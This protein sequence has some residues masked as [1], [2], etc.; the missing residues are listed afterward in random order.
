MTAV[1]GGSSLGPNTVGATIGGGG[2][3]SS[4]IP[5]IVTTLK[6]GSAS[7]TANTAL[8]SIG[9]LSS[10]QV[11]L[12]GG[13][14]T[15][16]HGSSPVT[17]AS[18]TLGVIVNNTDPQTI[19]LSG[20]NQTL[21]AG[22]GT[23]TINAT[24][25][26]DSIVSGG[27]NNVIDFTSTSTNGQ[28]LGDGSNWVS[29]NSASGTTTV[30]ATPS[31]VDTITGGSGSAGIKYVSAAGAF[32]L[33]DPGAHNATVVGTAGGTE[34]VSVFGGLAFTGHL[35]VI[36]GSGTLQGGSAGGNIMGTSSLSGGTE[37]IGGGAGD[38]LTSYGISDTIIAGLGVETL[39]GAGVLGGEVFDPSSSTATVS[40][41]GSYTGLAVK[42][43]FIDLHLAGT[44]QILGDTVVGTI[45]GGAAQFATIADFEH[46]NDKLQLSVS[47]TYTIATGTASGGGVYSTVTTSNGSVFTFLGVTV[48]N[49]DIIKI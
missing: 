6:T 11:S 26:S 38:V 36:D 3:S 41:T 47:S 16:S 44:S 22:I 9:S 30:L 31:T 27:G 49:N 32:A 5:V 21:Y 12:I 42:G 48:N 8:Q 20:D 18:S 13:S 10:G 33:I 15:G 37:L 17:V 1:S 43:S 24:G 2:G 35:T 40:G 45:T 29:I 23:L 28:F 46:G 7:I 39:Q 4:L 34:V 14:S 25:A 19:T